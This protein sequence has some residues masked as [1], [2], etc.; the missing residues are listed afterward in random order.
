MLLRIR[1]SK[2]WE[3]GR[4]ESQNRIEKNK[5]LKNSQRIQEM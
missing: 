2:I 1:T 5:N 3:V 4:S